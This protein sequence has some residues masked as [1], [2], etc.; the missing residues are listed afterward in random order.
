MRGWGGGGKRIGNQ[1]HDRGQA[2]DLSLHYEGV[3]PAL[4][5]TRTENRL[6]PP[7]PGRVRVVSSGR[8]RNPLPVQALPPSLLL[9]PASP[10]A[11]AAPKPRDS[12]APLEV[13]TPG[14]PALQVG[15]APR[16]SRRAPAGA[17][18]PLASPS[19]PLNLDGTLAAAAA[20]GASAVRLRGTRLPGGRGASRA[21]RRSSS[22]GAAAGN[23]GAHF[24]RGGRPQGAH[25]HPGARPRL[26][27]PLAVCTLPPPRRAPPSQC[28][29][30]PGPPA[31]PG[32][33]AVGCEGWR[34]RWEVLRPQAERPACRTLRPGRAA[35]QLLA[36]APGGDDPEA[37]HGT[38]DTGAWSG[39][40]FPRS[41]S[42]LTGIP[43]S[44]AGA[45]GSKF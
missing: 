41:N 9:P 43:V 3:Q 32:S 39:A 24:R 4:R 45:R 25:S 44:A 18:F 31:L 26:G 20:A 29:A 28:L 30:P 38:G 35:T 1:G 16:P 15:A 14:L 13:P 42:K 36:V 19:G 8:P 10:A 23:S 34:A 7:L 33:R 2:G 27:P 40:C 11:P 17:R 12:A 21:P 37:E 22:R 6:A 5:G